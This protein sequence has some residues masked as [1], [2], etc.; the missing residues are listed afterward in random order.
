[1][2]N[3]TTM[4][5]VTFPNADGHSLCGIVHEPHHPRTD[6]GIILLP[7]GVKARDTITPDGPEE[8]G[9]YLHGA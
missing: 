2:A 1:M 7:A 9:P 3:M 4:R 5:A 8:A 6:L